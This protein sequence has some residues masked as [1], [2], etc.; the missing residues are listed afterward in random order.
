MQCWINGPAADGLDN[1]IGIGNTA[2]QRLR[3]DRRRPE[4]QG[5]DLVAGI[6]AHAS[7]VL[8]VSSL[9]SQLE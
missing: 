8:Q 6:V 1:K 3:L 4:F 9:R 2:G 7:P 5:C